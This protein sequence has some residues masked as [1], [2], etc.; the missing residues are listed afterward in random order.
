[1]IEN[2]E[3]ELKDLKQF[4]AN[5]RKYTDPEELT[6]EMLNDWLIRYSST[7]PIRAMDTENKKSRFTTM[8]S[9]SLTCPP[10]KRTIAS[11]FTAESRAT[12]KPYKTARGIVTQIGHNTSY[13]Q[14]LPYGA[15]TSMSALIMNQTVKQ[16][17][18]SLFDTALP[19]T[20]T[21]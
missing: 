1:M 11:C 21:I 15:A 3:E 6:A 12:K 16:Y 17:I 7:L 20:Y 9:A 5:V 18:P 8:L 10:P 4:L 14:I 13:I 2:G 19:N